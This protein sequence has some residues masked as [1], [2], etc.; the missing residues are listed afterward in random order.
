[1]LYITLRQLE[2]ITAVAR[3]GS[4]SDAAQSLN[5]SQP[6][7]SVAI[8]QVEAHLGQKIF[9][10]RK[11]AAIA[12]A[13]HGKA[14]IEKAEDVLAAAS[15]LENIDT[16]ASAG[17][18]R[19]TL[20]CFEDLAPRYLAPALHHLRGMRPDIHITPHIS[21]FAGLAEGMRSG[22]IDFAL[23]YDLGLDAN[24]D[25]IAFTQAVPHA[26]FPPD[27][28]LAAAS[29]VSLKKL[30]KRPLILSDEGLSIQHMLGLFRTAGLL[31]RVTHRASSL[32]LMRSL[33]ANG[34]GVGI[35]YT[36]PPG[37]MSY[38]GKPVRT[39]RIVD[40]HAVEPIILARSNLAAAV[41]PVPELMELLKG[42]S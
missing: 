24:Y 7:V 5:V 21:D 6:A 12:L 33:A 26:F 37:D 27:D 31:P 17:V 38:D 11:G 40:K 14:F 41:S 34:E 28:A 32:E 9:L 3:A 36:T 42:L 18:N 13:T 29:T 4:I 22:Q 20:G 16:L 25:R 19:I 23:T 2:Y 35:S 1:M 39:A 8:T 15:H 30:A 10:R